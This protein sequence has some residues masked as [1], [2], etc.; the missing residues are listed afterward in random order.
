MSQTN[1]VDRYVRIIQQMEE[2]FLKNE[3]DSILLD[4]FRRKLSAEFKLE[5]TYD[6]D[7]G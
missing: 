1:S 4:R 2:F 3:G 5:I 7:I 6:S